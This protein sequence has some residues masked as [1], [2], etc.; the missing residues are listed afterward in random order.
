MTQKVSTVYV[1]QVFYL[2]TET[3]KDK[4][5]LEIRC[6]PVKKSIQSKALIIFAYDISLVVPLE[7]HQVDV[8]WFLELLCDSR[9][10]VASL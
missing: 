1:F 5:I 9:G 7:F 4:K 8:M 3:H 2:K 6:F 10:Y